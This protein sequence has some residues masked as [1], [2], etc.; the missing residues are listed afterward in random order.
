M[1]ATSRSRLGYSSQWYRQRRLRASCSSRV[2][3]DVITTAGGVMRAHRAD[4]G[5]RDREVGE[6]LEQERLELV[7][8][9]VELVD[10]EHRAGALANRLKQRPLDEELL[11]EELGGPPLRIGRAVLDRASVQQL[12]GVVPLVQRL[13]R[14]DALVALQADELGAERGGER[15]R[16]SVLPTPGSPSSRRGRCIASARYMPTARP[17][18]QR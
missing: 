3:F 5:D 4:L 18:S 15:P 6:H 16:A 2:R 8:G 12:A 14:V 9:A 1:I 7:V 13:A 11:A 17:S 10:Q